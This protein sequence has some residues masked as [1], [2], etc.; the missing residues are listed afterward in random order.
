MRRRPLACTALPVRARNRP[1]SKAHLARLRSLAP[2]Q[3]GDSILTSSRTLP[4]SLLLSTA[5]LA[6]APAIHAQEAASAAPQPAQQQ[7]APATPAE[8]IGEPELRSF[9]RAVIDLEAIQRE[10]GPQIE[11]APEEARPELQQQAQQRMTSAVQRHNLAPESFNRI[12]AAVRQDAELAA[13][14]RVYL[15]EETGAR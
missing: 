6:A 14:V 2:E 11:A 10:I 12:A 3:V 8:T 15:E 5:A 13:Q 1:V 4:F 9:A 7:P